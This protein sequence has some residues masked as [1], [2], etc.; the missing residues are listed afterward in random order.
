MK[1][2]SRLS[3]FLSSLLFISS[4][5]AADVRALWAMDDGRDLTVSDSSGNENHGQ[6]R[7]AYWSQGVRSAALQIHTGGSVEIPHSDSLNITD[8][9]TIEAWVKPWNPRFPDRPTIVSKEGAYAMHF[10]PGKAMTFS[11]F[12][13]GKQQMLSSKKT[14]WTNGIWQHVVATYDGSS[15]KLYVNSELDNEKAVSGE[16]ATNKSPVYIGS[17]KR[18]KALSGTVDEIKISADVATPE[19]VYAS[20]DA[21]SIDLTR[22][23]SRFTAY[24]NK[25]TGKRD[26]KA[27]VPGNVW[28]EAEDFD[29]YGGWW[30]DTQFVPRMGSPYLLAAGIG[31]PVE[32][33]TTTI[34]LEE[35]GTYKLWVR[36]RNWIQDHAPGKFQ[37]GVHGKFSATTF[38]TADSN[39]WVWQD[40]GSFELD[41]GN[42]DLVIKDL[43]GY[44]GR[45]DALLLTKDAAYEPPVEMAAYKAARDRFTGKSTDLK[46]VDD[47]DVVVV[48]GGVAG[49]NAAISA[50]R[51]GAKT[52]LIQD[53]PII[54]GNNS[55]EMGVPVLGPA[56]YG[57]KNS[58]ESG[59]NEEIGRYQ[60]YNYLSKWATGAE[61]I[62]AQE[63]NLTVF[64]NR[65]V[66]DVEM[67]GNK[68]TGVRAFDMITTETTRYTGKVF[69]DCT[70]DGWLGYYTDS[71][72]MLG[73]ETKETFGEEHAS[74]IKDSLTMSGSLFQGSILAYK[75][76]DTGEP[77]EMDSPAWLWDLTE[78]GF[79]LE[80][81]KGFDKSHLSGNWWHENRNDVDDLWD[82]EGARDGLIRVSLSY[83][84]WIKK[85][86][87]LKD[88]VKNFKIEKLPVTNAKR[89]TRRLVGDHILTESDV[90]NAVLFDDRIGSGGW[91]LDIHHKDGIFSKEGPF[92]FN[93]HLP[94]YSVPFRILY[95][96]DIDNMLFAGRHVSVSRVALGTVRVQ[97]TTGI[98]GQ[99]AGTAAALCV[100]HGTN[101]RGVYRSHLAELQQELL[102]DDQYIIDLKN[103]DP[104]DLA[105]TAKVSASSIAS[106]TGFGVDQVLPT[107]MTHALN[108]E[109]A[110]MFAS[111]ELSNIGKVYLLIKSDNAQPTELSLD[112]KGLAKFGD[113]TWADDLGTSKVMVP[114][115][116]EHWVEFPV[117]ITLT[118]GRHIGLFLKPV[119]G[120]SWSLMEHGPSSSCRGYLNTTSGDWSA[121]SG[122]YYAFYI[123][124][125]ITGE[126]A[127]KAGNVNNGVSRIVDNQ[128][129]MWKS[130]PAQSMPQ[131]VQ[132][133]LDEPKAINT[134]Y[135][136][137][138]TN[139]NQAKHQTWEWKVTDR[140]VPES[141][142]GYEVQYHNGSDW[143]T[144]VKVEDNYQ[145]RRIHEFPE[146][147]TDKMRVLI[148]KT[149]GDPSARI[150]E[151]RLY[152]E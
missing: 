132:L 69:I 19:A 63:E 76:K 121:I 113:F 80:E 124:S 134:I 119:E 5:A 40:G 116:G 123:D 62:A 53:R 74:D 82:P 22:T 101:P 83:I 75:T 140:I 71:E 100:K 78:N 146:V 128:M 145:R 21:G 35:A 88:T 60:S 11:L 117:G 16:I 34:T 93:T 92:D 33:A 23:E 147:T 17:V 151:I 95:S 47:Y 37:V 18:R 122:Q 51:N 15:M 39:E 102:K 103:E 112:V 143:V 148:T 107:G 67:E 31:Y 131:W 57:K 90:K 108:H 68:I 127:F 99:A 45:V 136:T 144:L 52:V 70:G 91:G 3:L 4:T 106:Q 133:Q 137:F 29:S 1:I 56:D 111:G 149:N 30:M 24:Y 64:L 50:A 142:K 125:K 59:L 73:R 8:A 32:D 54:G 12:L 9:V 7:D 104:N 48:G 86:S 27:V 129:N 135:L 36:N 118:N 61:H 26:P 141:V 109:R 79:A 46:F 115:N 20:Y 130:D 87:K 38:G 72:Y 84:N 43:T 126:S 77:Y 44:Y 49:A 13:N 97:G 25:G 152:N 6:A 98:M 110:V 105:R 138:D 139:L 89:E 150:Y 114:A 14:D 66:Y 85:H 28:I 81:R 94:T 2:T 96:K 41:A 55:A 120:L 10:G 42:V 65:H 58:R